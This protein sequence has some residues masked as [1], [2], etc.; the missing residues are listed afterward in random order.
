MCLC[1]CE[2]VWRVCGSWVGAGVYGC[3]VWGVAAWGV[4]KYCF[5]SEDC[6]CV[7]SH[8][9]VVCGRLCAVIE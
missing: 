6:I 1:G 8:V 3:R 4:D 9:F 7:V 5:V 2:C